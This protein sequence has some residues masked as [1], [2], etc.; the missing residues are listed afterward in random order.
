MKK[1]VVLLLALLASTG[2]KASEVGAPLSQLAHSPT[3]LA[4]AIA[5]GGTNSNWALSAGAR[6]AGGQESMNIET[7]VDRAIENFSQ[8]LEQRIFA[9]LKQL[10]SAR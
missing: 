7:Y 1:Y 2:A 6:P 5:E 10:Q 4:V 9:R 3:L 8:Q